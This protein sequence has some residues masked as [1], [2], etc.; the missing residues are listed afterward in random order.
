MF[1][2]DLQCQPSCGG[3]QFALRSIGLTMHSGMY[4]CLDKENFNGR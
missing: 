2:T 4:V 3:F 1:Q